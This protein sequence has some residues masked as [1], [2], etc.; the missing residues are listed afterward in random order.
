MILVQSRLGCL[1]YPATWALLTVCVGI[2]LALWY[3]QRAVAYWVR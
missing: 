2:P 1:V 3:L